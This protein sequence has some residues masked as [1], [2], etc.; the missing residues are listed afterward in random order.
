[1]GKI[2]LGAVLVLSAGSHSVTGPAV[3]IQDLGDDI[4]R[5]LRARR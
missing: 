4:A 1:M 5:I 2:E 3:A